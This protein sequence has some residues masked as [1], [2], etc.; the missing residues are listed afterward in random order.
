MDYND[1][2]DRKTKGQKIRSAIVVTL[3]I[4]WIL[5]LV[6]L[7]IVRNPKNVRTYF[8][9]VKSEIHFINEN[10][11][12]QNNQF[13]QLKEEIEQDNTLKIDKDFKA[14]Y[15]AIYQ[16]LMLNKKEIAKGEVL[17]FDDNGYFTLAMPYVVSFD[18]VIADDFVDSDELFGIL[19]LDFISFS[20]TSKGNNLT[21]NAPTRFSIRFHKRL[22]NP[23]WYVENKDIETKSFKL[24]FYSLSLLLSSNKE[25]ENLQY[26]TQLNQ[27]ITKKE[28]EKNI[29][30]KNFSLYSLE[31][32]REKKINDVKITGNSTGDKYLTFE[33]TVPKG[34]KQLKLIVNFNDIM[35]Q[36]FES[37][38][39]DF[40]KDDVN[41][42]V[43]V[44]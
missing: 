43:V 2:D 1:Y 26:T 8:K 23:S 39:L 35:Y 40:L 18:N 17:S 21:F 13:F 38:K 11:D 12:Y 37:L 33:N 6:V 20:Y 31:D 28:S 14:K 29:I 10:S 7:V 19:G 9:T 32:E 27:P 41:F 44:N 3:S 4:L 25:F 5:F 30:S 42:Q 16:I 34:E 24:N 36:K 22:D 15:P